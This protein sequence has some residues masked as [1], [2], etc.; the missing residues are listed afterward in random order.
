MLRSGKITNLNQDSSSSSSNERHNQVVQQ[1]ETHRKSA[2]EKNSK[3]S[4]TYRHADS[5]ISSIF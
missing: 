2:E 5:G 1:I 3:G 4:S